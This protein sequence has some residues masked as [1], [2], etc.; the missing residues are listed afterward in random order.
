MPKKPNSKLQLIDLSQIDFNL[1]LSH[2]CRRLGIPHTTLKRY[3]K[4]L[5]VYSKF[6]YSGTA[7]RRGWNK[8]L[9]KENCP[10]I[11][12]QADTLKARVVSGQL[13]R[14]NKGKNK[15]NSDSVRKHAAHLSSII[16]AKVANGTWHVSF[17]TRK[18]YV[19]KGEKFHGTWELKFAQWLDSVKI[20]WV[21]T[22]NKFQ[23]NF[24][25]KLRFYTPDFYLPDNDLYVE[26]KGYPVAKDYSKWNQFPLKLLVITGKE[27]NPIIGVS[28][29]EV[30]GLVGL[31]PTT[32]SLTGSCSTIELQAN[33][34]GK[35]SGRGDSNP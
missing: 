16:R 31:E 29:R 26:I 28:Y 9:S 6:K 33:K 5:G 24:D 2:Y 23:Y 7:D 10:S 25:G 15:L 17:S 20:N 11:K 27:L 35:W 13:V 34:F 14:K 12:L 22:K 8:G 30:A 19:Y 4:Q 32:F 21:R 3:F 1:P 18:T